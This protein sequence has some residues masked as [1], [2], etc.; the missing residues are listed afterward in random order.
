MKVKRYDIRK[1]IHLYVYLTD[2]QVRHLVELG[3]DLGAGTLNESVRHCVRV[4]MK[5]NALEREGR[6]LALVDPVRKKAQRL[7]MI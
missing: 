7:I 2:D 4:V 6:Y 5:L 1:K 3:S